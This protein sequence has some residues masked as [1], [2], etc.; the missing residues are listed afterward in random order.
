M[1]RPVLLL[2]F[3]ATVCYR[4]ASRAFFRSFLSANVTHHL[5]LALINKVNNSIFYS[6]A[7]T[8][9]SKNING[10]EQ[11]KKRASKQTIVVVLYCEECFI[12]TNGLFDILITREVVGNASE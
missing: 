7:R 3:R 6:A 10:R 8:D 9:S 1:L 2:A 11:K 5:L 12:L 4:L